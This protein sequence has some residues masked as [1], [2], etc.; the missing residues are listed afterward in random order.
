MRTISTS[1]SNKDRGKKWFLKNLIHME[2]SVDDALTASM[3]P[4]NAQRTCCKH[5]MREMD[6]PSAAGK[7]M[8]KWPK[9]KHIR[10]LQDLDGFIPGVAGSSMDVPQK[11]KTR[12]PQGICGFLASTDVTST[13]TISLAHLANAQCTSL[14]GLRIG[15]RV[16][17][18]HAQHSAWQ[19]SQLNT[20]LLCIAMPVKVSFQQQLPLTSENDQSLTVHHFYT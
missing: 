13:F 10:Q 11:R 9:T 1:G 17:S 8:H 20:G 19:L 4:P 15:R 12:I 14:F 16:A 7:N 3:R 5:L 2:V 6:A 18:T